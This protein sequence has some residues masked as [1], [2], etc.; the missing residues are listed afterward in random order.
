[1]TFKA[2]HEFRGLKLAKVAKLN[3]YV[4]SENYLYTLPPSKVTKLKELPKPGELWFYGDRDRV[5]LVTTS[6]DLVNPTGQVV[7]YREEMDDERSLWDYHKLLN[8]DGSLAD[9]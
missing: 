5:R 4:D 8:A 1:M 6:G 3:E 7:V 2:T 9:G